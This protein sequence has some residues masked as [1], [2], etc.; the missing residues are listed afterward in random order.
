M[1]AIGYLHLASVYE[2]SES[3]DIVPVR[4]SF[5][6][7]TWKK[8]STA[9]AMRLLSVALT[10]GILSVAGQA[11]AVQKGS[12]GA[13]VTTIQRCLNK[14]GFFRGP[15][16]GKFGSLTQQAVIG[17]QQTN[18]LPADG[19][20][21]NST[22]QRLQQACQSKIP[23]NIQKTSSNNISGG[24]QLGSRGPA[25]IKLQQR[26]QRLGYFQ[27]P[28]TGYFGP[29]TQQALSRQTIAR[30]ERALT[31]FKQSSQ[32]RNN[33]IVPATTRQTNLNRTS[34][35]SLST[36][37][38][39]ELQQHLQDLGYLKANATG[40][41][42]SLTQD[43]LIRFQ[44]DY[45]LSADGMANAQA[46]DALRQVSVNRNANQPEPNYLPTDTQNRPEKNYLTI[47]DSGENVK[48][49]QE[50]LLQI[51][52]FN[53]NPDGYFGENTRSYVYAFQQYSRINPTGIV[54]SQTWQALGLNTSPIENRPNTNRYV[55]VVP[56]RNA[57]TLDKVR[58]YIPNLVVEKS[59]LGNYINAGAFG[60]RQEAENL[61]K[62]LRS[63]GFDARVEYF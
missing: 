13:E 6:F 30:S 57:D 52:F 59:G 43:A 17:F 34:G 53:A 16:T 22:Q 18:K 55:V 31:R 5:P 9:T 10:M 14:L 62:K 21:G 50:R 32:L 33:T 47:G 58:Q 27:G 56:I 46:L 39:R 24:L 15:I 11:L 20:V 29:K 37:Q 61:S 41:F 12:N 54:D 44:R 63:Y 25:V 45:R 26:L 1:E 28:V 4:V 60:D 42:G 40:Y 23:R 48:A 49:L 51:G 35:V 3:L 7:L 36:E 19:V 8:L 2:A 38:V